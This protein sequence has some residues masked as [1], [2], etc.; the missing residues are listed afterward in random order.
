MQKHLTYSVFYADR[1]NID[2]KE[3]S[4]KISVLYWQKHSRREEFNEFYISFVMGILVKVLLFLILVLLFF[5]PIR[6]IM[7]ASE[8]VLLPNNMLVV[9]FL[10]TIGYASIVAILGFHFNWASV[11]YLVIKSGSK[12]FSKKHSAKIIKPIMKYSRT[13]DGTG[14]KWILKGALSKNI[15]DITMSKKCRNTHCEEYNLIFHFKKPS[16]GQIFLRY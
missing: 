15:G 4:P 8:S 10:V 7:P 13:I 12:L 6:A 1:I 11:F 14:V 2:F 9:S 16:T 3:P 5:N